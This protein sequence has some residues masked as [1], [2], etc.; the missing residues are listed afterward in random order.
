VEFLEPQ[1]TIGEAVSCS[2]TGL[3]TG[4]PARVRLVPAAEDAG[5]AVVRAVDGRRVEIPARPEFVI[6]TERATTLAREGVCAATVEHL[7]AALYGLGVDNLRVE[8]DGP[9]LPALDGSAAPWVDLLRRAGTCPQAAPRRPLALGREVEVRE[10]E[11]WIRAEPADRLSLAYAIEYDHP[12]VRRQEIAFEGDDP[13]RFARELAPARSFGFASELPDLERAGLAR[14][15]SLASAVLV[16]EQGVVNSEGLRF[17]DE[18]VRHKLLDLLGDLALLGARLR[19]R[20]R[21]ER[22]GHRLHQALV[23]KLH[24]EAAPGTPP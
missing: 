22:G 8:L 11:R 20:V 10:G 9:E 6:S 18:F 1:R 19:A 7:L 14:G 17:P 4:A 21:V 3:H 13:E 24:A 5:I 23:A 15:G 12:A 16:G 2:G